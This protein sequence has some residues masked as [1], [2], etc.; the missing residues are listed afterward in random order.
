MMRFGRRAFWKRLEPQ[1]RLGPWKGV[2]EARH[3][4]W[5]I[6]IIDL[7]S[8]LFGWSI[9]HAEHGRIWHQGGGSASAE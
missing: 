1:P 7:G 9:R 8:G 4:G 3:R 5:T 2:W 6:I